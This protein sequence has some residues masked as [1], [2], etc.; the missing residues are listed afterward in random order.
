VSYRVTLIRAAGLIVAISLLAGLSPEFA[1]AD[2]L[3]RS[4]SRAAAFIAVGHESDVFDGSR[5]ARCICPYT[6]HIDLG[7]VAITPTF[8]WFYRNTH[9]PIGLRKLYQLNAVLLI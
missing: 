9:S 6:S 2:D 7:S 5:F 4:K 1:S 3:T 8:Y